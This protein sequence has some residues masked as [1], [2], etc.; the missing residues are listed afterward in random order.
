MLVIY[1]IS[2]VV[3]TKSSIFENLPVGVC[4]HSPNAVLTA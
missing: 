3:Q 4:S 2:L 1:Q